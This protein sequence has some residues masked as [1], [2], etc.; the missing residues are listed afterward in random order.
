MEL[1]LPRRPR[2]F[3]ARETTPKPGREALPEDDPWAGEDDA[4]MD[5]DVRRTEP[6]E[7][8]RFFRG[9]V[10]GAVAGAVLWGLI[11]LVLVYWL[12]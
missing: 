5:D 10:F 8:V 6:D 9:A 12:G 4:W 3:A 1:R 11:A 7:V 2:I